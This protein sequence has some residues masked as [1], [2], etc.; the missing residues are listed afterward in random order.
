MSYEKKGYFAIFAAVVLWS[1]SGFIVKTVDASAI[2]I[3]LIRSAVGGI[4]LAGF[5]RSKPIRPRKYVI[6]AAIAMALFLLTLTIT[7]QISTS[8][9]A[10]SLQY[11]AP[12]YLI[13][14]NFIKDKKIEKKNLLVFAF[15]FIGV[16]VNI[17][18]IFK[19]KNYFAIFTGLAIG[20]S[21]VFYSQF[22]QKVREGNPL[23]IVSIINLICCG[24]YA[25]ALPFNFGSPPR[26]ISDIVLIVLA[27]ILISG[28]SYALYSWGLRRVKL[29][30]AVIIG[31][32]EPILN[33]IWVLLFNGEVPPKNVIIGMIF[34]L[35]GALVD[36]FLNK[37]KEE[38]KEMQ[39]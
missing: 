23:G 24:L 21:F 19:E 20:L 15:I 2:W 8:A 39:A 32:S 4:F 1:L 35:G 14:Y 5:I 17:L 26:K 36:I 37:D 27:G 16:I 34:I 22:L 11:T 30:R 28:L 33:P 12:M 38:V 13:V 3:T 10:I 29:E 25:L 7:T 31:L 9:M 18:G 6:L